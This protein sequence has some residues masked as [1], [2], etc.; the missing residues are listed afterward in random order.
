MSYFCFQPRVIDDQRTFAFKAF[1]DYTTRLTKASTK[2]QT[3]TTAKQEA[4]V[5][6]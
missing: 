2:S 3:Y 6:R 4:T 5:A 1:V